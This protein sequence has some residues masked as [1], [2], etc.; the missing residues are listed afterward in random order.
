MDGVGN[1]EINIQLDDEHLA[2]LYEE[3]I[4]GNGN[5]TVEVQLVDTGIWTPV[6]GPGILGLTDN[7]NEFSLSVD[8]EYYDLTPE[9][10][11]E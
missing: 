1:L 3:G 5:W 4:A 7:S 10:G 8:Y 2:R 6:L 9:E 11:G